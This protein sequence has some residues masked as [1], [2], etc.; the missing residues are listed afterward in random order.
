MKA[1]HPGLIRVL[2]AALRWPF[3]HVSAFVGLVLFG[4][5]LVAQNWEGT[6]RTLDQLRAAESDNLTWNLTQV[7][8]DFLSLV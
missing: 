6:Q 3:W 5:V 7:E 4:L 1:S 8:V 2:A